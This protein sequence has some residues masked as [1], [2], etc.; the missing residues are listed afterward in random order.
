M[1]TRFLPVLAAVVGFSCP[2][3]A[4][5]SKEA[6]DTSKAVDW[7]VRQQS[8]NGSWEAP[9][10]NYTVATT[11]LAGL[12]LLAEGHTPSQ[13]KYAANVRRAVDWLSDRC[14]QD[15]RIAL[16]DD[17]QYL[18]GHGYALLFLASAAALDTGDKEGKNEL[19]VASIRR[20]ETLAVV[21]RAAD[22]SIAAQTPAGGWWYNKQATRQFDE[23]APT[24][25]QIQA[26]AAARQAG[27]KV[28]AKVF[29]R[30]HEY[31]TAA[32]TPR[33]GGNDKPLTPAN[34]AA[35]VVI[36]S[37]ARERN[38]EAAKRGLT[39][40]AGTFPS[41]KA[42]PFTTLWVAQAWH[43]VGDDGYGRLFPKVARKDAQQYGSTAFQDAASTHFGGTQHADGSWSDTMTGP[44]FATATA[45]VVL[46]MPNEEIPLDRRG[47]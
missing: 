7:L 31:V 8:R 1:Q 5:E 20:Q 23:V 22:F 46:N 28:P 26:L 29:A 2:A 32:I 24:V 30:A 34:A 4:D 19:P 21:R 18:W 33:G 38:S 11:G 41:A 6:P 39:R 3:F 9:N 36:A 17:T 37:H 43:Q 16:K 45:L 15:G 14:Q 44:V 40:L 25:V 42:D 10:G 12:A 35:A 27:E 47:K 13:G